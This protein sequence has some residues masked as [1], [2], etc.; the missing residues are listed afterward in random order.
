[1]LMIQNCA[2][3]K[4]VL[5]L[6][7]YLRCSLIKNKLLSLTSL[8]I[9]IKQ[10]WFPI[11]DNC[12]NKFIKEITPQLLALSDLDPHVRNCQKVAGKKQDCER[13]ERT[14]LRQWLGGIWRDILPITEVSVLKIKWHKAQ[15]WKT[16]ITVKC[17]AV[18][19]HG[20]AWVQKVQGG[21]IYSTWYYECNFVNPN[22]KQLDVSQSQD[23]IGIFWV[24][25]TEEKNKNHTKVLKGEKSENM[26]WLECNWI[27]LEYVKAECRK[28]QNPSS[29]DQLKRIICEAWQNISP[30]I[31]A[32]L[33]RST[34]KR[35]QS[36]IKNKRQTKS[37]LISIF[38]VYF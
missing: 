10:W 2:L 11:K 30:L 16:S 37:N 1:M 31:S 7:W 24:K 14:Q 17:G 19:W 38:N 12:I 29:K 22:N 27:P 34:P 15:P 3:T 21:G 18:Y 25:Y 26:T 20:A 9:L 33:L 35:V 6:S 8:K 28:Q 5:F 4:H 32:R 36:D 13:W 23:T